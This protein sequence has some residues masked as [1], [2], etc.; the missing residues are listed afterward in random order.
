MGWSLQRAL[1]TH[2]TLLVLACRRVTFSVNVINNSIFHPR[3]FF[4]S[5]KTVNFIEYGLGFTIEISHSV[6]QPVT[7]FSPLI[8]SLNKV[9]RTATKN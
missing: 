4:F 8:R 7:Y 2:G 6:S 3:Y 1:Y 5:F 9:L